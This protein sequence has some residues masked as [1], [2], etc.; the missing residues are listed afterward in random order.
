M[1][2]HLPL[3]QYVRD[4]RQDALSTA[5]PLPTLEPA[6][7]IVITIAT[8]T[9]LR[10]S[11]GGYIKGPP[12]HK[13]NTPFDLPLSTDRSNTSPRSNFSPSHRNQSRSHRRQE[14]GGGG[15]PDRLWS[16]RWYQSTRRSFLDLLSPSPT[17]PEPPV[18]R[19]PPRIAAAR[20]RSP[21]F[22]VDD[23]DEPEPSDSCLILRPL[24]AYRFGV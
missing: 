22:S 6:C 1:L 21:A 3:C 13:L 4:T 9:P 18:S 24:L 8:V 10:P 14:Q 2:D 12:S 23:R 20:V 5:L 11:R 19:R 7:S 17:S 16:R 15:D